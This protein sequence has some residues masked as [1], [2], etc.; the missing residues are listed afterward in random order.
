MTDISSVSDIPDGEDLTEAQMKAIINRI[1][2]NI[3]NLLAGKWDLV[4]YAEFGEAG[5]RKDPDKLIKSLRELRDYWEKRLHE[6]PYNH[7][8]VLDDPYF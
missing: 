3:Y 6:L 8:S 1:D 4:P 2:R 7:I 5:H